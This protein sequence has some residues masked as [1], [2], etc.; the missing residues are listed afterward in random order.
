MIN[1]KMV[2]FSDRKENLPISNPKTLP[3][4]DIQKSITKRTRKR[5]N[6]DKSQPREFFEV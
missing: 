2:R 3:K 6:T 1:V 5:V 4:N